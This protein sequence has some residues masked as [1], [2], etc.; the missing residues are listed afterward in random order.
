LAAVD[1][2][3]TIGG[4][5]G[6]KLLGGF[7]GTAPILSHGDFRWS[8]PENRPGVEVGCWRD[9]GDRLRRLSARVLQA[10][11]CTRRGFSLMAL[12]GMNEAAG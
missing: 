5:V 7:G 1:A 4:F 9:D 3:S 8:V 10:V 11:G 12:N 6:R 2:A